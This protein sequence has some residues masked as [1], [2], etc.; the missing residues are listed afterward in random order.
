MIVN[1]VEE[2][3]RSIDELNFMV[4]ELVYFLLML[5]VVRSVL[6]A[7]EKFLK[8]VSKKIA[9]TDPSTRQWRLSGVDMPDIETFEE[10]YRLARAKKAEADRQIA[11]IAVANDLDDEFYLI[12][13]AEQ[14]QHTR[15]PMPSE[16]AKSK[17]RT[18]TN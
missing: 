16:S 4:F 6:M 8:S 7:K 5:F 18:V 11:K 17:T 9:N 13:P 15:R 12:D 1:R 2:T 10:S 14:A 3:S